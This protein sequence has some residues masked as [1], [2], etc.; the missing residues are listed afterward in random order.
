MKLTVPRRAAGGL[1]T[2]LLVVTLALCPG[3]GRPPQVV[4]DEECF[5]AVDALWTA[6]TSK[7][8][9]LVEQTATE[10]DRLQSEGSLSEA[11]HESLQ[12]IIEQARATEWQ[13]AAEKLKAFMLGQRKARP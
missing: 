6:V 11:G 5:Q 7:R 1:F 4:H 9:D 10:L 3:C 2:G 12:R 13:A 8:S